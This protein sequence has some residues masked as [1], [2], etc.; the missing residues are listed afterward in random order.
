[1]AFTFTELWPRRVGRTKSMHP[2][3]DFLRPLR[4]CGSRVAVLAA[5]LVLAGCG[6]ALRVAYNQGDVAVRLAAHE[7]L[8]LHGEQSDVFKEQL[9]V[10]HAWHRTE[11]LPRYAELLD[12]AAKRVQKG[13]APEDVRWAAAAIRER[14]RVLTEQAVD[15][16]APVLVT[17]NADNVVALEKK[18]AANNARFAK[19]YLSPDEGRNERNRAKR[20]K[21]NFED[22]LGALSD[23]QEAMIEAYVRASPLIN[24]AMFEDRKRRQR[25]LVELLKANRGNPGLTAKVRIFMLDWEAQRG[26][27]YA[28]LAREQEERLTRLLVAMDKTLS[29]KQRQH[30][31]DRLEFYAKEFSILATQG[32]GAPKGSQRVAAPAAGGS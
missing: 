27:E 30:A 28:R 16:A 26:P 13:L 31:V 25:E 14:T 21:E 23:E 10:F 32:R 4:F 15:D 17:L 22:W 6:T 7:Y 8:D 29:P 18:L 2:A 3:R 9:K 11:E 1:M 19:D 5:A 12:G 24:A 20:M